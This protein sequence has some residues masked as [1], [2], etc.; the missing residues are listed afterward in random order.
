MAIITRKRFL[1][2]QENL[3]KLR[4]L[5]SRYGVSESKLVGRAIQTYDPEEACCSPIAEVLERNIAIA[6]L[7]NLTDALRS[8]QG[9]LE[10]TNSRVTET[11]IDLKDPA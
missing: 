8:A 4:E 7:N 3:I 11:L 5:T 1:L 9:S 2:S 10:R 6:L